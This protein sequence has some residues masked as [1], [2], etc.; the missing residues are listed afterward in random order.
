MQLFMF[1]CLYST[2]SPTQLGFRQD[3][4]LVFVYLQVKC[5]KCSTVVF[6][7]VVFSS[8]RLF[9]LHVEEKT[10]KKCLYCGL[11]LTSAVKF[12]LWK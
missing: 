10:N 5:T 4:L 12:A 3:K 11:R 2:A 6:H 8:G 9:S 1:K 7:E